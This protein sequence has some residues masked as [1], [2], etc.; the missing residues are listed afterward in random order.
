[1]LTQPDITDTELNSIR[2]PTLVL[3][4]H[5][6]FIKEEHT[7]SMA[8]NIPGSVLKILKGESHASYVLNSAKIYDIIMPFLSDA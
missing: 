5:H 6:D 1:M 3:A 4:G 2:T 7:V 8:K